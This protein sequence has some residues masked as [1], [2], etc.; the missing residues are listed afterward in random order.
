MTGAPESS[1]VVSPPHPVSVIAPV[2][3]REVVSTPL[4][5][6]VHTAH[7]QVIS[8]CR[9][10]YSILSDCEACELVVP[11]TGTHNMEHF[12]LSQDPL[13]AVEVLL[14]LANQV[15]GLSIPWSTFD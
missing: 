9:I 14:P 5:Y 4:F 3:H 7:L 6:V 13:N 2:P 10:G 15:L 12:V 8:S 1:V 11:V